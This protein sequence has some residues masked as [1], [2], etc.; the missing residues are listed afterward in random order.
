MAM[1]AYSAIP[2]IESDSKAG[3]K[4]IATQLGA[5]GTLLFCLICYAVSTYLA[6]QFLGL[7]ALVCA[8]AYFVMI[9]VSFYF[10]K[11]EKLFD[12]YRVFPLLNSLIGFALFWV[13]AFPK[14]RLIACRT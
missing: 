10:K 6:Y 7:F 9:I 2:D 8:V 4:T 13:I 3:I 12:V 14:L 5:T 11:S 1:H